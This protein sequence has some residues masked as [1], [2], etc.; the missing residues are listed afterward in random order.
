MSARGFR[1]VGWVAAVAGAAIACYMLSLNVAAERAELA[2]LERRIVSTHQSIRTLQ[3]ELGTRGR[4]TQLEQW[5]A[6]VLALSAPTAGQF[7]QNEFTLARLEVRDQGLDRATR[8]QMASAETVPSRPVSSIPAPQMAST[9]VTAASAF[10]EQ[11]QPLVRK[12]SLLMEERPVKVEKPVSDIKPAAQERRSAS[13][14]DDRLIQE[15]G[16]AARAEKSVAGP[17]N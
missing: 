12:A 1:P 11:A 17:G 7:L 5:N 15:I 8:V 14:L 16:A 13:L 9:A 2:S 3:T 4:L 6:E 10:G